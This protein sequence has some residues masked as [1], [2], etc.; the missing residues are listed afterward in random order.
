M[1]DY[2]FRMNFSKRRSATARR[3]EAPAEGQAG[4]DFD[5]V[6]QQYWQ[7]VCAIIYRVVGDWAE[8]EDLALEVFL[9]LHSRPPAQAGSQLSGWLYRV[10]TNL[11]LN[12]LRSRK[13]R[14]YY[15]TQAAVQDALERTSIDPAGALER[16]QE[17]Q[18]VQAILADMK[19]RAAQLLIL[20]QA[21]LSYAEISQALSVAPGSVG[22]LLARAEAEFVR[23]YRRQHQG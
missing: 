9:Q 16:S 17:R 22:T 21:G 10:G 4:I 14:Q 2:T 20:R 7:P 1:T 11:G 8:A 12:A 19:P 13:R 3:A 15:E 6:F 23:R 18:Q 5:A